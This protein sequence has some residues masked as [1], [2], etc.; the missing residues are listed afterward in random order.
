MGQNNHSSNSQYSSSIIAISGMQANSIYLNQNPYYLHLNEPS[1]TIMVPFQLTSLN[2]HVWVR[3][4]KCAMISKNMDG[5]LDGYIPTLEPFHPLHR[6]WKH[7]TNMIH[8]WLTNCMSPFITK[9]VDAIEN[10][11]D[12]WHSL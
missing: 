10:V 8:S 4:M 11:A 2:Y 9:S 3:K 6:H 7:C 5:F 1:L 12:V